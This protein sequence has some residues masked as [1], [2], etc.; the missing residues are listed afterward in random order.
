M[1]IKQTSKIVEYELMNK[2]YQ[3]NNINNNNKQHN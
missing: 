1:M 3:N 2:C